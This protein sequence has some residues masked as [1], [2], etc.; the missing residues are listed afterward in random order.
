MQEPSHPSE[1]QELQESK[2]SSPKIAAPVVYM[3]VCLLFIYTMSFQDTVVVET[4]S[5][6]FLQ[7]IAKLS[8]GFDTEKWEKIVMAEM[9]FLSY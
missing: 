4:D 1:I 7:F 2:N 8:P 3:Y 9:D 6:V 5:A